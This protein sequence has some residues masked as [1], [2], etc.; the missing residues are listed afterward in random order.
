MTNRLDGGEALL[1][2]FRSL[3]VDFVISSPGSEW[4]PLWEAVARQKTSGSAGPRYID[5]WHETLAVDIAIGYT[6]YTGR[7]QAVLLHAGAGLLQGTCGI[8][9]ALLAEVPLLVCSS[10]AITYGE[11]PS[12]DPGSQ[13]YRNLS[14]V[15]GTH[16]LVGGIVKWANQVGSVETL[17]EMV[18]RAGELAQRTP[19]GP[20]YLN[21]PVEV[22]LDAWSVPS[23]KMPVAAPARRISPPDEIEQLADLIGAA[24]NPIILTESA[25]RSADAFHA[26][27]AFAEAFGIPVI[28]TQ[29]TVCGNFPKTHPL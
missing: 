7:M 18:K 25:G 15:G 9:G 14:I 8:H 17:Y 27:V 12:V 20:V 4:A 26:L 19:R 3:G 11:R 10:E 2:A 13:W 1:E 16:G 6:L 28:E 22:L 23:C 21:I 5:V 29:G 24:E